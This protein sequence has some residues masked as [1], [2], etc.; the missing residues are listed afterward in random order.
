MLLSVFM[1]SLPSDITCCV[2][3]HARRTGVVLLLRFLCSLSRAWRQWKEGWGG[4][5]LVSRPRIP[6]VSGLESSHG[7]EG[8]CLCKTG[9][10]DPVWGS[11]CCSPDS[12][13]TPCLSDLTLEV[14]R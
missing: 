1:A 3:R 8:G 13:C 14:Q 10:P 5:G 4:V 6:K 9:V 12:A 2:W 7:G 11:P